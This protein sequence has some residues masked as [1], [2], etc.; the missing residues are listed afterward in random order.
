MSTTATPQTVSVTV[1]GDAAG[2]AQRITAG[3]HALAA[4]ESK[5]LGGTDTGPS[6]YELLL[7]ALGACTSMTISMY[8]RRKGFALTHVSVTL[9]HHKELGTERPD[10][11][12][13]VISLSGNLDDEQRQKLLEI[14][15]KCPVHRTLT[16][17]IDSRSRLA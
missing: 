13:R 5:A 9:T 7:S 16:T 6:P 12:E 14:A 15:E 11:I 10:K 1:A 8:A 17:G 3:A 4:D 2:L